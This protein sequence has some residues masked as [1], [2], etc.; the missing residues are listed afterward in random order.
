MSQPAY[1]AQDKAEKA[2]GE[3]DEIDQ[4]FSSSDDTLT[5]IIVADHQHDIKLRT[6]SW[7]KAAWL[8]AG[9][10]VC[11]AIMAQSWSLS[12]LGWVPGILTMLVAGALFWITSI[13]M[14]KFIMKHPQ[15]MDICDFGYYAF[16][17]SRIAYTFTGFMLLANN[18]LLI[19]FHILTGAK[20]LN[21]LSDH[22]L[23]TV[24]FSV[25]VMLM[26]IVMSAPRTLHHVSFMSMFSAA[27]MGVS[28]LLFL[29]FAGTEKAPLYG[30]NGNYPTDGPVRTY[31]FPLP[32]TTW[33][34]CMNA[35]LNITFLWV[36]QILFPTFISEME[37]PQDFPKSLAVLAGIS[38]V[39]FIVPP[40]IGFRYLG[41]YATAPAFGSLGAV[42]DKKASFA[43]VIVPTVVIAVIYANVS[44]KFI[45][46]RIIMRQSRH[47][48]SNTVVGW[49][50]WG[51]TMVVIWI[52]AFVFSEVVPS[53]GDFLS[54]LGAA[55]DSFFGF[56]FFAVAYWQL[57]RQDL[58]S[59]PRRAIMTAVHVLVLCCGLFLL[60]PG[61]YAAVEAIIADYSGGTAPAFSCAN[62][63]I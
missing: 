47:A 46:C 5:A 12:V 22:S 55:F 31:A 44:A 58:F 61:L 18:I 48:H 59:G 42:A 3:V 11:L 10:Q 63:A 52:L 53:M 2:P 50:V 36:P 17:K 33:V 16:G 21:T 35:V 20:I 9:E 25:I 26:G 34:A 8:L 27:C 15:I 28:I 19:G 6:M 54:L 40:A 43:F 4:D 7:Q 24:V 32:G 39:L 29:I 49:A 23:C 13:T 57:H 30:Y 41:Q 62:A 51:L 56:I 14:H 38:A 37:R 60:G 45:Y 1:V